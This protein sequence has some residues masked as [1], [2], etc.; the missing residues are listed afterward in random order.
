MWI[1]KQVLKYRYDIIGFGGNTS[2]PI[3]SDDAIEI[4][5]ERKECCE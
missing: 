3:G 4:T 5:F 2:L 1:L